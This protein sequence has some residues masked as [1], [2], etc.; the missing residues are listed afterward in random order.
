MDDNYISHISKLIKNLE[1][2]KELSLS[3][4]P[5]E[6]IDVLGE[7]NKLAILKIEKKSDNKVITHF[8]HEVPD[9][10]QNIEEII[11]SGYNLPYIGNEF[12]ENA[13]KLRVAN[14]SNNQVTIL[15]ANTI[16]RNLEVLL[17]QNNLLRELPISLQ[18]SN[19]LKEINISFNQFGSLPT[20]F[21]YLVKLEVLYAQECQI[22]EIPT[23]IVELKNI[24]IL[25]LRKNEIT[26]IPAYVYDLRK[27]KVLSLASNKIKSLPLF[28]CSFNLEQ[29][30]ITPNPIEWPFS[31][32]EVTQLISTD[33][34][35][36]MTALKEKLNGEQQ[37][38]RSK[39]ILFGA[40]QSGKKSLIHQ[41]TSTK[42]WKYSTPPTDIL[43]L[44]NIQSFELTVQ[45][46]LMQK[47]HTSPT[48]SNSGI[49]PKFFSNKKKEEESSVSLEF[50]RF[51]SEEFAK[52]VSRLFLSQ[53]SWYIILVSLI[54]PEMHN[55]V[56]YWLT[57]LKT[58]LNQKNSKSFYCFNSFG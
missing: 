26:V 47:Q 28:L 35:L 58:N 32:E 39:V 20:P 18:Y 23:W 6:S 24:Q 9:Y 19:H 16:S 48:K 8:S 30:E 14:F 38:L 41:L 34:K 15:N 3:N 55:S 43:S 12:F 22:K 33:H 45:S 44:I 49:M 51:Q 56:I 40:K 31:E 2:L 29:L 37:L 54:D 13:P 53:K 46:D 25:N 17:L 52:S 11:I 57:T 36:L 7:L 21:K 27:L 50:W 10:F 42:S 5:V 1:N 4:N